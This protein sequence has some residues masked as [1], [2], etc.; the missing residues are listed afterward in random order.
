[1]VQYALTMC[2]CMYVHMNVRIPV[3]TYMCA[4]VCTVTPTYIRTVYTYVSVGMWIV[5]SYM[6]A[7]SQK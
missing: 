7:V 4:R 1:M 2:V 6:L 3:H 5:S